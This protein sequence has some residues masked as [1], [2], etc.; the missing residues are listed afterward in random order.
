MAMVWI[1]AI[2]LISVAAAYALI[3]G[4]R[5]STMILHPRAHAYDT[6]VDKEVERGNFTRAWYDENVRLEE[7]TICSP[8]GYDLHC[9]LWPRGEGEPFA[10]GK[11]RVAVFAHGYT[12]CLLGGVKYASIFHGLGFDCVLYDHRNHGL[13][14]RAPTTMGFYE[15]KDLAVVCAW[16]RERFGGDALIGT[17]GESMGAATVMLHAAQDER[18][19]FAVEDCGYSDLNAEMRHAMRRQY[20]VPA[21]PALP[22][23]S[24]LSRLRGGVSFGSVVPKDALRACAHVPM[25]F[26]HGDADDLVPFS[27]LKEN[28]EAK[29]GI[30]KM[31]TVAGADHAGCYRSDNG[32]YRKTVTDFLLENSVIERREPGK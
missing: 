27:M 29:A 12:Y 5:V 2:A 23:A 11:R 28:Y 7:F 31:L 9:A 24:L 17:H 6:V 21:Y 15:A 20:H 1:I 30:K 4:L 26:V 19:A 18:L 16:A 8:F 13:S 14:G 25:L 3:G 32:V 22:V 10:D